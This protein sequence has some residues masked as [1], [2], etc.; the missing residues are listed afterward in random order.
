MTISGQPPRVFFAVGE[1]SGDLHGSLIIQH[2]KKA[3]PE[4][5]A[6]GIGGPL[7]TGA[8]FKALHSIDELGVIGFV[9]VLS[10][11]GRLL[12][13]Y[14]DVKRHFLDKRPD[15]LVLIDYPGFNV[16]LA[17]AARAI[18]IRVL[19]YICPQVWAW[20]AG[21]SVKIA[22]VIDEAIVVFPFE[23]EIWKRAGA[24]VHWFGHPLVD[25]V[26]AK[27]TPAAFRMEFNL[28]DGPVVSLLPGSRNQEI[29]Y[30]LPALLATAERILAE[31]PTTKFLLPMA[32]TID[33]A[34]I[35]PH[36]RGR[37]LPLKLLRDRTYD[38]VAA[39]DLALV[40]SGTATL[41]CALLGTPMI[42]VY[43]TNF[44]TS[45][46]SKFLIQAPHIGLPNVIAG[47]KI[48]PEFIRW[49]FQP[50]PVAREALAILGDE[51]RRKIMRERLA[52]VRSQLGEANAGHRVAEHILSRLQMTR[53][54]S[55]GKTL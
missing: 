22:R 36:L 6:E 29:Y 7:M 3:A 39:S 30:I 28:G 17:E 16:R 50:E 26:G 8:G 46:L 43:Q 23:V 15:L 27:T 13:I 12:K 48:V 52:G 2:L 55:A 45:V 37:K 47:E 10:N 42:I 14:K 21:R 49:Q 4:L 44:F 19:Y 40:A 38:A 35:E 33:E 24:E 20:H 54:E 11:L 18:G 9:E 32:G 34:Q 51:K 1:H 41:E 25:I 5:I 31:R 53:T